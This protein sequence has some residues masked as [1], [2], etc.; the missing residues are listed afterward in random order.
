[1]LCARTKEG[2]QIILAKLPKAQIERLRTTPFFCPECGNAVIV[3]AGPKVIPHFA[4]ETDAVCSVRGGEG[5]YHQKGK[6]LL[7]EWLKK[8]YRTTQLERY[9]PEIKQ[10]P[11]IFIELKN[12][13]IAI[14]FQCAT[15]PAS[16]IRKRTLA[17]KKIHITS[18]WILGANRFKR[19]TNTHLRLNS[20]TLQ[21]THQFSPTLPTMLFYFCPQTEII[22][23]A[24]DLHMVSTNRAIT[25]LSF[26]KLHRLTF[27]Q[28][29]IPET[30]T[31][32]HIFSH[33]Q[34]EKSKFRLMGGRA[35]GNELKWRYWLYEKGLYREMLPSAVYLPIKSQHQ[36][37]V[38]L[39][40]WQSRFLISF[41]EPLS[42][43]ETFT[44]Q[45]AMQFLRP[46]R[47]SDDF[48]PLLDAATNPVEEY[49]HLLENVQLIQRDRRGHYVK[50][51][52][53][54]FYEHIDEAMKG[55]TELLHGLMY[56]RIQE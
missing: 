48:Y 44:L 53:L 4:H 54:P 9:L 42:V 28:L 45:E 7:Y 30:F 47:C 14:E 24:Q 19:I 43:G 1:M 2:K 41:L 15:I 20:F 33:W 50:R 39:W 25:K 11:D 52:S 13:R 56:N 16:E 6:L 5:A 17:Y 27:S 23:L 36:M 34:K 10:R 21:F 40:N 18:I 12:R 55:D 22:S 35:Y 32:G 31:T 26:Q 49:I 8:Q 38:P 46:F 3:R 37:N 51:T 29:F